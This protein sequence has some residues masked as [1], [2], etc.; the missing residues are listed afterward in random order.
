LGTRG[1]SCDTLKAEIQA[2]LDAKGVT[3]YT[4][5]IM[6]REDVKGRHIVGSCEGNTKKIA[7]NRSQH[8]Q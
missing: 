4:L 8:A 6:A 2:K 5:T 1:K 3:D 7:L